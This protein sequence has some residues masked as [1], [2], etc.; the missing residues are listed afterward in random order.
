MIC[1]IVGAGEFSSLD[2]AP[3]AG[4]IVIAADGGYA[5]LRAIGVK[6]DLLMGDFDSLAADALPLELPVKRYPEE[7]D[8]TDMGIAVREGWQRGARVFRLYGGA[9]GRVD[10]LLANIQLM[11]RYSRMGCDMRLVGSEYD[12]FTVTNGTLPLPERPKGTLAS[13]FCNGD[14]ARGVT[15]HGLHYPLQNATLRCDY[16]LGVSNCY[17]SP[18]EASV[19]VENGTLFVL[20]Y[21][22]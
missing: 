20:V 6:P 22:K 19:S 8:D 21:C 12:L 4:D 18:K 15:L 11:C 2:F 9:G 10:H 7:K 14:E 13:V 17:E 5:T 16:A 3:R 1:W